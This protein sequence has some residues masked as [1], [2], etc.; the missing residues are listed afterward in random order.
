MS[1]TL[2]VDKFKVQPFSQMLNSWSYPSS[3]KINCNWFGST[4]FFVLVLRPMVI[5]LL[6]LK[7]RQDSEILLQSAG[8][9]QYNALYFK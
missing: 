4:T 7:I 8:G 3:K 5:V 6:L 9:T 1:S 2:T